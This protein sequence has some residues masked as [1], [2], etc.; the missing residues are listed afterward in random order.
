MI[1]FLAILT[2]ANIVVSR[3]L[4]AGGAQKNGLYM[5]TLMNYLTGLIT[6][7]IV[8][9]IAG[10]NGSFL[11]PDFKAS[12]LFM[13]LGGAVGMLCIFLSNYVT[14]RMPAFLLTLLLFISQLITAL[15]LD[16]VL[17]GTFSLGRLIGGALVLVGLWHYQWVHKKAEEK[18][19]KDVS[20]SEVQSR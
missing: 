18:E 6:S 4:N 12:S 14:P 11:N 15:M 1:I 17:S 9:W 20:A 16:F 19:A 13:Y 10:E 2:G 3:T 8:L 7:L 5:S